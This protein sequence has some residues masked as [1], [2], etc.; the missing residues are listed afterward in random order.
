[1][2]Y[3]IYLWHWPVILIVKQYTSWPEVPTIAA[4]V[5][6]SLLVATASYRWIE[7]P[8]LLRYA[9]RFPRTTPE[10]ERAHRERL[11]ASTDTQP[12]LVATAPGPEPELAPAAPSAGS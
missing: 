5:L 4:Q 11:A 7:R 9:P 2:T 12:D 1:M 8:I 3:G 6:L 10:R